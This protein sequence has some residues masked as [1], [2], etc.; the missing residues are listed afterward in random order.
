[1]IDHQ[2]VVGRPELRREILH[3]ASEK[4]GHERAARGRGK[5]FPLAEQLVGHLTDFAVD[6]L[7]ENEDVVWHVLSL[8]K[9][10]FAEQCVELVGDLLRTAFDHLGVPRGLRLEQPRDLRA[11]TRLDCG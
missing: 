3:P 10:L 4:N 1:M 5:L 6:V 7:D 11:G 2:H 8:Y 9:A